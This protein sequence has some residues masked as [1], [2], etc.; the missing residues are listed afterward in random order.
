MAR[1][2][3]PN[4]A[5][6]TES[7]AAFCPACGT[8][9]AVPATAAGLSGAPT[10]RAERRPLTVLFCDIVGSVSLANTLDPE[11]MMQVLQAFQTSCDDLIARH[12]GYVAKY[13]GDGVLAYFGYPS[14][15]E[16][17]ASHAV[18]AALALQSA[19]G[20]LPL[21]AG[22]SCKARVGV[23]TGLVVINDL[24][25]RGELREVGVVGETPN[26]AARL[27]SAAPA[28][29]VVVAEATQRITA[30]QFTYRPLE[31]LTLKGFD[32]PVQAFEALDATES[33]SRSR[34]RA[35]SAR[36]PIFGRD[37]ELQIL[38]DRWSK[39]QAGEGQVVLL[40]GEAGIGKSRLVEAL[41][42]HVADTP[43]VQST[44]SCGPN[45]ADSALYRSPSR[46]RGRPASSEANPPTRG[47][48]SSNG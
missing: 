5:N 31:P 38:V 42:R 6:E 2:K 37:H 7:E 43:H 28:G 4:C 10:R 32:K 30:G 26:L 12:G 33:G 8:P 45:T 19:M 3:C 11:D 25:S 27:Q 34:A 48:P 46:L 47:A 15:D 17:D 1:A 40:R 16:E 23:A 9:L 44:W 22:I 24:V 39:V 18:R 21:P 41:R 14:A 29:G 20:S 13:L 35:E 36:T